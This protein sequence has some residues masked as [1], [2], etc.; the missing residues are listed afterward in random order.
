[1]AILKSS[2]DGVSS[3]A[4]NV[5]NYN[6]LDEN[7]KKFSTSAWSGNGTTAQNLKASMATIAQHAAYKVDTPTYQA[8]RSGDINTYP[9]VMVNSKQVKG[10]E[11]GKIVSFV[12]ATGPTQLELVY[13]DGSSE[14]VALAHITTNSNLAGVD[15]K[16]NA[17]PEVGK[18][19]EG[20]IL[21]HE[22]L[23][24]GFKN[25]NMVLDI[26]KLRTDSLGTGAIT[27]AQ[28]AFED[29]TAIT[30]LPFVNDYG[31]ATDQRGELNVMLVDIGKAIPLLPSKDPAWAD[32]VN[33]I[34]PQYL[35]QRFAAFLKLNPD[36][37][38]AAALPTT[39][40]NQSVIAMRDTAR[41]DFNKLYGTDDLRRQEILSKCDSETEIIKI[42]DVWLKVPPTHVTIAQMRT[43]YSVPIL[44]RESKPISNSTNR[45]AIKMNVIFSGEEAINNELKRIIVQYTYCPFN[46][47]RSVDLVGKLIGEGHVILSP[48]AGTDYI[49]VTM[50]SYTVYT[51]DGHPGSLGATF[52]F[53]LFNY[54][55]YFNGDTFE[56]LEYYK[57]DK[58]ARTIS[59]LKDLSLKTTIKDEKDATIPKTLVLE[60][61][62]HPYNLFVEEILNDPDRVWFA[63]DSSL[64]IHKIDR[65]KFHQAVEASNGQAEE[66]SR[67]L[68][69]IVD[70][71]IEEEAHSLAVT[72]Q[73]NFAWIPIIGMSIPTAQ[74][75]GP[76]ETN[77]DINFKTTNSETISK[78]LKTYR[79]EYDRGPNYGTY[80][81]RYIIANG[82]TKLCLTEV[83]TLQS[84]IITSLDGHPGLSDVNLSLTK[85]S[86]IYNA[87]YIN[88]AAQQDSY[89]GLS[90]VVAI[91]QSDEAVK[92]RVGKIIER[93]K[94][95]SLADGEN[96]ILD[97]MA[98]NSF[99][100]I[101]PDLSVFKKATRAILSSYFLIADDPK[102]GIMGLIDSRAQLYST[103]T[104]NRARTKYKQ[105]AQLLALVTDVVSRKAG[106]NESKIFNN[107]KFFIRSTNPEWGGGN[108]TFAEALAG[109]IYED[110]L[111]LPES[112]VGVIKSLENWQINKMS[113]FADEEF[114]ELP[115]YSSSY[116]T[117][118][119]TSGLNTITKGQLLAMLDKTATAEQRMNAKVLLMA[120]FKDAFEETWNQ[121]QAFAND[122]RALY[123]YFEGDYR[124]HAILR[125]YGKM[126][127]QCKEYLAT[128]GEDG[129]SGNWILEVDI[130]SERDISTNSSVR[131]WVA[132]Y[133][134]LIRGVVEGTGTYGESVENQSEEEVPEGEVILEPELMKIKPWGGHRYFPWIDNF[135]AASM[136]DSATMGDWYV[137]YKVTN[138]YEFLDKIKTDVVDFVSPSMNTT[139]WKNVYARESFSAEEG[140]TF[141]DLIDKDSPLSPIIA[142]TM[143]TR[144]KDMNV[145][146]VKDGKVV[147]DDERKESSLTKAMMDPK[148]IG[149]AGWARSIVEGR[150]RP[151]TSLTSTSML[152]DCAYGRMNALR[153][154]AE[155]FITSTYSARLYNNDKKQEQGDIVNVADG[156]SRGIAI[157]RA[158]GRTVGP[159]SSTLVSDCHPIIKDNTKLGAPMPRYGTLMELQG[160]L[161]LLSRCPAAYYLSSMGYTDSIGAVSEYVF[162]AE[163]PIRD[164]NSTKFTLS[165]SDTLAPSGDV[166]INTFT[167]A[168]S[169]DPSNLNGLWKDTID[170]MPGYQ[171][172]SIAEF[173]SNTWRPMIDA[174]QITSTGYGSDASATP[175]NAVDKAIYNYYK[176]DTT[177]LTEQAAAYSMSNDKPWTGGEV[178]NADMKSAANQSA[179]N[180]LKSMMPTDGLENAFPTYKLYVIKSDTSDYKYY[181][182]DDY[183]DFRLVQDLMVIR[184]KNNPVHLLRCRIVIDPKYISTEI[185]PNQI[186][187]RNVFE[188]SS[189]YSPQNIKDTEE[190]TRIFSDGSAGIYGASVVPLRTGMRI[191]L[192]LGYST[193]PRML[194]TVFIGTITSLSGNK[195]TYIYEIEAHG[196]GRELIS[197]PSS[198]AENISGNNYA[199]IISKIL[200]SNPQVAHFGQIYGSF[201]ERFGRSHISVMAMF[202]DSW[203]SGLIFGAG[204]GI[205][206]TAAFLGPKQLFRYMALTAAGASIA[207]LYKPL[208]HVPDIWTEEV[209]HKWWGKQGE[210]GYLSVLAGRIREIGCSFAGALYNNEKASLEI[211]Q[212]FYKI[213]QSG[214][215]P[216]DDNIYAPDIWNKLWHG[217]N[218]NINNKTTI[219]D[220]LQNIKRLYP[221]YALDVRPYGNRSTLFLG[222]AEWNYFRTDD[223]IQ[224]MAPSLTS[225][226][227]L[228]TD[229]YAEG[230]REAI[231][232]LGPKLNRYGEF[233]E[234]TKFFNA[235]APFIPFQKHHMVSSFKDI[236]HNGIKA[237]P[238]RGWNHITV[239]YAKN[240]KD[241]E[242]SDK[243][244]E[245]CIDADI[246]PTYLIKKF[247]SINWTDN[248]DV[249]NQYAIGR[250]KEGAERLYGGT[251]I[252][253]GNSKIEPY[254]KIYIADKV[255][256]MYGW[257]EVETVIHKFDSEMGYTTHI[258]PNLVCS[259]NH[260]SYLSTA[261][262]FKRIMFE[263]IGTI[264][265]GGVLQAIGGYALGSMGVWVLAALAFIAGGAFLIS[266]V[267][268]SD[269]AKNR[270]ANPDTAAMERRE[271]EYVPMLAKEAMGFNAMVS[272][273]EFGYFFGGLMH[274]LRGAD[275]FIMSERMYSAEQRVL[276]RNAAR[277]KF[278]AR[279]IL[280]NVKGFATTLAEK[281]AAH[282]RKSLIDQI[283]TIL[284]KESAEI[285]GMS[286]IEIAKALEEATFGAGAESTVARN[287]LKK[288]N[289]MSD[290]AKA[291]TT[292]PVAAAVEAEAGATITAM[293]KRSFGERLALSPFGTIIHAAPMKAGIAYL[294]LTC[295]EMIPQLFESMAIKSITKNNAIIVHPIWYRNSLLMQ[296]MEGYKNNDAFMFGKGI[297]AD[298]KKTI[299][300]TL[301]Q[302]G[303]YTSVNW[304]GI[305]KLENPNRNVVNPLPGA[306]ADMSPSE[307]KKAYPGTPLSLADLQAVPPGKG[308]EY[309]KWKLE[310][311][312]KKNQDIATPE[313]L[314]SWVLG[315]F[316][317]YK[318]TTPLLD[319]LMIAT[320]IEC[321][322]SFNA[323]A[324]SSD[325]G[326]MQLSAGQDGSHGKEW[327]DKIIREMAQD[328]DW[329]K[330]KTPA[331]PRSWEDLSDNHVKYAKWVIFAGVKHIAE[332]A[333]DAETRYMGEYKGT[334][335]W[336]KRE[337]IHKLSYWRYNGMQCRGFDADNNPIPKGESSKQLKHNYDVEK[338]YA[339]K[340]YAV[341]KW[342]KEKA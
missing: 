65:E 25:P 192:R 304:T 165:P 300:N 162:N 98:K 282:S 66:M 251:L 37:A 73:N 273:G 320:T 1:M 13:T 331:F 24:E 181:S 174:T 14:Q 20:T 50:D 230:I 279:E 69:L 94:T 28:V 139:V 240:Q 125:N 321:E 238:D 299:D 183:Y 271:Y 207:T 185:R 325:I 9:T 318:N 147:R 287:L 118:N 225:M 291:L 115:E 297:I 103:V 128:E 58:N 200:R 55:S 277:A 107:W 266:Q 315:A 117:K 307:F 306:M 112:N 228:S 80:D 6:L 236:I 72:Y 204:A 290:L 341:I 137:N 263:H 222:P 123:F 126:T 64:L 180:I 326:L 169:S 111:L 328:A 38:N 122:G 177:N 167:K 333:I 29:Q 76:G 16:G 92:A 332:R 70:S 196:D 42:G 215:N 302:I 194:D 274:W 342:C 173:E 161:G 104:D 171:G 136:L 124:E 280:T 15:A 114:A 254:D 234:G 149:W 182:L 175:T 212:H 275:E 21:L 157:K 313:V 259:V 268:G 281:W 216:I 130:K 244:T 203:K 305:S 48:Y 140:A 68:N 186:T 224:A 110:K 292:K 91:A 17:V 184:D 293:A 298:Y 133:V 314:F 265:V 249:A 23:Q 250:L 285:L 34:T 276:S 210:H 329:I 2:Y 336:A 84:S 99:N 319:P 121:K 90:R 135:V 18:A 296:G 138:L 237:T 39:P 22:T 119:I 272:A 253:R 269:E 56:R 323:H 221:N 233:A 166:W 258:V 156:N 257:V 226:S 337:V 19:V 262:V 35:N 242:D 168:G 71:T 4:A 205:S 155:G 108:I 239:Q 241:V 116:F 178:T 187:S 256:K 264:G 170:G 160:Q 316:N 95:N 93:E 176:K 193:D 127:T 152:T 102:T 27:P 294:L 286:E 195:D 322:S 334:D 243:V 172:S 208:T 154:E 59:Q 32:A 10:V 31:I 36:V 158:D 47:I 317:K 150:D 12:K 164:F 144:L 246:D 309:I 310:Q 89:W 301:R 261:Q 252:I 109:G 54:N 295:I 311:M 44:G 270:K 278:R 232:N 85:E 339:E 209:M 40:Q 324:K 213:F 190:D 338:N 211:G 330:T 79:P 327:V 97:K 229:M 106:W 81:G 26:Q 214:N 142:N 8:Y 3:V 189:P 132:L 33:S 197:A 245:F 134:L 7:K 289:L 51:L 223:P 220:V 63:E 143:P 88:K 61:A 202:K 260:D 283:A 247:E 53:S 151:P 308:I 87:R 217:V 179:E 113:R 141:K 67:R 219:W 227:L 77:V 120:L 41:R 62:I 163:G 49:P 206:A 191:A 267:I 45:L 145:N 101:P 248:E 188:G 312:N 146:Y 288:K 52:Q 153:K 231:K 83:L 199:D 303:D 148:T 82:V 75:V 100:G 335:P 340:R 60:D 284:K 46:L 5:W 105:I 30:G 78:V 159:V 129:V 255:N 43:T 74:Y 131:R 235:V 218:F 57:Y 11:P 201:I 86:Y 96:D 198:R